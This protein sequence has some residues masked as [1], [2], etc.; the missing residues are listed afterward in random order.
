MS[1]IA[2]TRAAFANAAR[3]SPVLFVLLVANGP[4]YAQTQSPLKPVKAAVVVKNGAIAE[5][6]TG[7]PGDAVRGRGIV[8]SRELGNCMLCHA[9]PDADGT[10][11]AGNVGPPLAGVGARMSAGEL[12]LRLVD[13][14]LTN[15]DSVMPAYHRTADLKQV[16]AIYRGK[17]VLDAQQVEDVIAWLQG[18]R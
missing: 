8:T 3:A 12:R 6:L 9:F 7:V 4:G 14:T 15:P 17:P 16:A 10:R 2:G 1:R 13:S 11:V 18:L 5:S